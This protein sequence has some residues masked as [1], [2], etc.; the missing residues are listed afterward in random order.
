VVLG[1]ILLWFCTGRRVLR[2]VLLGKVAVKS[3]MTELGQGLEALGAR[4]KCVGTSG[5]TTREDV[6]LTTTSPSEAKLVKEA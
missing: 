2:R 1:S 6:L 3:G 4:A 5:L